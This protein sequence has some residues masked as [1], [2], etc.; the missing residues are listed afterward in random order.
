MCT[1]WRIKMSET[2]KQQIH[3]DVTSLTPQSWLFE[4]ETILKFQVPV[5]QRLFTWRD[6]QFNRLLYD[7]EEHCK[8]LQSYDS[9]YYLGIITVVKRNEQYILV[10][11]QQRLTVIA[12]LASILEDNNHLSHISTFLDYEARPDD[13]KSLQ[14]IVQYGH[15]WLED[16]KGKSQDEK[17]EE[18]NNANIVN[19]SMKKFVLHID[20]N[21]KTWKKLWEFI[22]TKL[23]LFI[24]LLP[25]EYELNIRLQNEYFEKMNSSGKQLEPHE[26]LK[27]R[28]CQN[29]NEIEIWNKIEDFT[30]IFQN[31]S[32]IEN[33]KSVC[34]IKAIDDAS[35]LPEK[36][37][38]LRKSSLEKWYPSL[39]DFPIF[40]LHVFKIS[41]DLITGD[42][43]YTL[44]YDSHKLLEEFEKLQNKCDKQ[45]FITKI[46]IIMQEY[47]T[48]LDKWIIHKEVLAEKNIDNISDYSSDDTRFKYW[49][50]HDTESVYFAKEEA[51]NNE[52]NN[53]ENDE[54]SNY[55][56]KNITQKLKQIQMAL[57]ALEG[58]NQPW[59]IKAYYI[60]HKYS[61]EKSEDEKIE[62]L[63]Q[64]L[65]NYLIIK[66]SFIQ[67]DFAQKIYWPDGIKYSILYGKCKPADFV[68]LDYLLWLL[69]NSTENELDKSGRE[70]KVKIFGN[71]PIPEA[72]IKFIPRAN[73]SIEHFHP[74]TDTNS[75]H[76]GETEDGKDN[77]P[78]W[79]ATIEQDNSKSYKD[80]FGN[81]ALISTGRNSEYRNYSV[82]E[83][84][85]RIQKQNIQQSIESIKLWLMTEECKGIDNN[86]TP[87]IAREH[88]EKMM[89]VVM[90][91]IQLVTI[92]HLLPEQISC[93]KQLC[94][95]SS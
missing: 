66:T 43:N 55:K 19:E 26:I 22:K 48:F 62:Y 70:L 67:N 60:I 91:G 45:E 61:K 24:S 71:S 1:V 47:R 69:V 20:Q 80:I 37:S 32:S 33:T 81:L 83:K 36:K 18:L 44:P 59:L 63:F 29:E 4:A 51:F 89:E 35:V 21:Q 92:N 34:L 68:C 58:S 40:L 93:V 5:Y 56:I 78:G 53:K 15:N 6:S 90:W 50:K 14:T 16:W 46:I 72:I 13:G 73:R 94:N 10:D 17:E 2:S 57:Y 84:S 52:E 88:E 11:G 7:L 9:Y 25:P 38:N 31:I 65:L 8:K 82:N 41:F 76:V 54:L 27:V 75:C 74:Q 23:K 77:R 30:K 42:E 64:N 12:I 79:G 39:I 86:W 87:L 3:N 85:A 28:I 49:N 95:C